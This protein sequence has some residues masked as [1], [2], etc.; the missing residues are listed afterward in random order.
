MKEGKKEEKK[1]KQ[2]TFAYFVETTVLIPFLLFFCFDN[3]M[4]IK[5]YILLN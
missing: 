5:K 1:Q 3:C 2:I 4:Y